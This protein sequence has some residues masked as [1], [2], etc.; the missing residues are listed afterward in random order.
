MISDKFD[1]DKFTELGLKIKE[2]EDK[3]NNI[4][5]A[6]VYDD[7]YEWNEEIEKDKKNKVKNWYKS[8]IYD[9]TTGNIIGH[10]YNKMIL[11][12]NADKMIKSLIENN[13]TYK[14]YIRTCYEGTGILVYN[15]NGIWFVSTKRC[16]DC[17]TENYYKD[18]SYYDMF[19]QCIE[20]KFTLD[21][22]NK[23]YVYHFNIIHYKDIHGVSYDNT[24]FKTI[25]LC[26][27]T[28]KGTNEIINDVEFIKKIESY[29]VIIDS[30]II[31]EVKSIEEINKYLEILNEENKNDDDF[32]NLKYSGLIIEFYDKDNN[33]YLMKKLTILFDYI[34]KNNLIFCEKNNP[35]FDILYMYYMNQ[36]D[37]ILKKIIEND[38]TTHNINKYLDFVDDVFDKLTSLIHKIYFSTRNKN[39][40]EKYEQLPKE[41]KDLLYKIHGV[42]IKN[43]NDGIPFK[44]SPDFIKDFLK[45]LPYNEFKRI[46][47]LSNNL[48]TIF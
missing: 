24:M 5:I 39:N 27:I 17:K 41:Y 31:K 38:F 2:Y 47:L 36:H 37:E 45:Q 7:N 19:L 48:K 32:Y 6:L 18:T 9:K 28:K 23:D 33:L 12:E 26:L 44:V 43:K 13:E 40:A 30:K 16:I 46:L 42:F 21:D 20:G 8:V 1:I 10:Q 34:Y 4:N 35:K 22:L 29:D 14:M 25:E 15:I 11:N 3:E